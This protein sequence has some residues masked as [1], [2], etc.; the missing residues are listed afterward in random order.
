MTN[1]P[2]GGGVPPDDFEALTDLP[3]DA[4]EPLTDEGPR[5]AAATG[6][7][8]LYDPPAESAADLGE[9]PAALR[10]APAPPEYATFYDPPG[11]D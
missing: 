6:Y 4:I 10:R 2:G 3:T 9:V 8:G 7:D 5:V 1:Q 11:E